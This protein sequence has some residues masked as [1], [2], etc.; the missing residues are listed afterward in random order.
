MRLRI[1]GTSYQEPEPLR[2]R[3]V[4]PSEPP[5]EIRSI[6]P[7][8]PPRKL[9]VTVPPTAA[10]KKLPL[11]TWRQVERLPGE[12][13][14]DQWEKDPPEVSSMAPPAE[15]IARLLSRILRTPLIGTKRLTQPIPVEIQMP[16]L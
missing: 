3:K 8:T 5:E 2:R 14:V 9:L 15:L 12:G 16:P 1:D 13:L 11:S 4:K 10:S 6:R 7:K